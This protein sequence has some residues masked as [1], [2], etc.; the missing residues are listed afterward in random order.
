MAGRT[1]RS[2][3]FPWLWGLGFGTV[4]AA[5]LF[6]FNQ[7]LTV[8]QTGVS[9]DL[10]MYT[11]GVAVA[12]GCAI[13]AVVSTF[14]Q[15]AH[16]HSRLCIFL[17]CLI[18]RLFLYRVSFLC[19]HAQE[20]LFSQVLLEI[21]AIGLLLTSLPTCTTHSQRIIIAMALHPL[22][23]LIGFH[24]PV[25]ISGPSEKVLQLTAQ[26]L[27]AQSLWYLFAYFPGVLLA[28]SS[29]PPQVQQDRAAGHVIGSS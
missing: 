17:A 4:A 18:F 28:I 11:F 14:L 22:W 5:L 7:Q 8:S 19:L 29:A 12:L 27:A 15:K 24:P 23:C 3:V 21:T 20:L 16:R 1:L 10:P 6:T 25:V 2:V 9:I 13:G 26:E